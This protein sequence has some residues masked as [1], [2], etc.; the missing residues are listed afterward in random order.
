MMMIAGLYR[1]NKAKHVVHSGSV[2][3]V[4]HAG[5]N[6][7]IIIRLIPPVFAPTLS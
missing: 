5:R 3:R 2:Q 7:F 6:V 4:Q 1:P